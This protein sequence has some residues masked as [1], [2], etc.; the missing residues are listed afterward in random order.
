MARVMISLPDLIVCHQSGC[1]QADQFAYR[2]SA[3]ASRSRCRG[4]RLGLR[5][6]RDLAGCHFVA[7]DIASRAL[8]PEPATLHPPPTRLEMVAACGWPPACGCVSSSSSGI[9]AGAVPGRPEPGRSH[10]V[11]PETRERRIPPR[12]GQAPP[13]LNGLSLAATMIPIRSMMAF[14]SSNNGSRIEPV[15]SRLFDESGPTV[16]RWLIIADPS[17][18]NSG[19]CS[20]EIVGVFL[21]CRACIIFPTHAAHDDAP[22]YPGLF[23]SQPRFFR[24]FRLRRRSL[25]SS[26][27]ISPDG[28]SR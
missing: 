5:L 10:I 25:N 19:T 9:G 1:V 4:M 18:S 12:F 2:R 13:G 28:G 7:Q 3:A 14:S 11:L 8:A 24:N 23:I 27:M 6:K 15:G 20:T 16:S 22:A 26:L 17:R 21:R